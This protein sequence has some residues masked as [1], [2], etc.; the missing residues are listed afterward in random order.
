MTTHNK[1]TIVSM[2]V[3]TTVVCSLLHEGLGHGVTA[4]LR[5]D[6]VTQ[7][8]SNHLSSVRPDRLVDAGG[9]LVN[10]IVGAL[11]LLAAARLRNANSRYFLW[12]LGAC[13]LLQGAGYF[14]FSGVLNLGDWADLIVGLPRPVALRIAMAA[15]GAVLYVLSVRW[16]GTV[17]HPYV[18]RR[19][20]YNT[21]GRLPYLAACCFDCLA[22]A[23]DP[24][25][26]RL[27]LLSTIPAAFGGLS[28]LLWADS[29][30]PRTAPAQELT[31][32]RSPRWWVAAVALGVVFLLTVAR[33]IEF[34]RG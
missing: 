18:P 1:T 3:V 14:L 32:R 28:G 25:G 7:L 8:T 4:W 21:A 19:G 13:N 30:M 33:G 16:I 34:H 10:L 17:V 6:I 22:G 31:V 27:M 15:T 2:A 29:L 20:V 11:C 24:L 26:L 23:F 9:T 5:G 12:F